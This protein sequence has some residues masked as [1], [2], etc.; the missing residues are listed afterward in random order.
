MSMFEPSAYRQEFNKRDEKYEEHRAG[1][2]LIANN[3]A[4][5]MRAG[6]DIADPE[7]QE[8]IGKRIPDPPPDAAPVPVALDGKTLPDGKL[9]LKRYRE[10]RA[11]VARRTRRSSS[12]VLPLNITPAITSIQPPVSWNPP[13]TADPSDPAARDHRRGA[14]HVACRHRPRRA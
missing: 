4:D 8:W 2:D 6:K 10:G 14:D 11:I 13:L 5:L 1:H 9:D 7:V 3:I 12:S